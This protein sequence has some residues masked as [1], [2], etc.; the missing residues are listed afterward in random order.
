MSDF[1]LLNNRN[2]IDIFIGDTVLIKE[3][4]VEL[5]FPYLSGP[6]LC[7]LCTQFGY[8]QE[9]IEGSI[10]SRWKYMQILLEFLDERNKIP[11]LLS[12][13]F[14]FAR[15]ESTLKFLNDTTQIKYYYEQLV[16]KA[17]TT[18]N[19]T[20]IFSQKEFKILNNQYVIANISEQPFIEAP[21]IKKITLSYVSD[22]PERIKT[23]L[24]THN[25]DSVVTKSRTLIEEV[26][27]FI[28]EDHLKQNFKF[29]GDLPSLYKQCKQLL[30]MSQNGDWDKRINE[31]LSGLDKIINAIS[32]M[33]NS[34]SDAHGVGQKRI[35]IKE[36]EA[37]LIKN[38]SITF[39]EYVL[40][41][42]L[43]K[44]ENNKE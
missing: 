11:T 40:S 8:P 10:L 28:I 26:L 31:M 21:K 37:I 42:Y 20:L 3:E 19:A 12:Y 36:R 27:I 2:I 7:S 15:F 23:D 17:T 38:A 5:R 33:R 14:E 9:Y 30:G 4:E 22:L 39:S 32:S 43:S 44:T 6:N 16:N 34:N 29:N 24:E 41:I 13:L 35:N 1:N 25:Y 18:I